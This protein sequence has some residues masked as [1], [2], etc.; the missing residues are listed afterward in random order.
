VTVA[1]TA[2]TSAQLWLTKGLKSSWAALTTGGLFFLFFV[3]V[4]AE[5]GDSKKRK[6]YLLAGLVISTIAFSGCGGGS[7]GGGGG[8]TGTPSGSY[9]ITVS[10]TSGSI[11]Q[12]TALK[13]TVQ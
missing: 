12:T 13:L 7:S 5:P 9:T 8:N 2:K 10:G 6:K 11:K 1:T 3:L 4:P